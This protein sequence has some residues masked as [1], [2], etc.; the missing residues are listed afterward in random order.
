MEVLKKNLEMKLSESDAAHEQHMVRQPAGGSPV[1]GRSE[2]V[3]PV[4]VAHVCA[5]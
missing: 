3:P 5:V 4:G 2:L 1:G